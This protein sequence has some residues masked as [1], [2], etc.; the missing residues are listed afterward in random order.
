MKLE[1]AKI[2]ICFLSV[3]TQILAKGDLVQ[4]LPT[5]NGELLPPSPPPLVGSSA[6]LHRG[7]RSQ[8]AKRRMKD[9]EM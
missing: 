9:L 2:Q 4:I 3:Q 6:L 1:L 8:S 5:L 7:Q